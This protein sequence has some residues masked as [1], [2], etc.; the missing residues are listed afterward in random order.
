MVTRWEV[1]DF[2]AVLILMQIIFSSFMVFI[3]NY[4]VIILIANAR[5]VFLGT[6]PYFKLFIIQYT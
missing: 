4:K 3:P 5:D 6:T 2:S 1:Q